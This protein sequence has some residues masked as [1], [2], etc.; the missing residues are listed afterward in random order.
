MQTIKDHYEKQCDGAYVISD[1]SKF[2][3]NKNLKLEA[4]TLAV[5]ARLGSKKI[6]LRKKIQMIMQ[7]VNRA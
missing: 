1:Q 7:E 6:S 4:V 2:E 5:E 3:R